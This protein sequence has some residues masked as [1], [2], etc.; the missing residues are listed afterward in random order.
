MSS[1][2]KLIRFFGG[3]SLVPLTVFAFNNSSTNNQARGDFNQST[4]AAIRTN[5][6]NYANHIVMWLEKYGRQIQQTRDMPDCEL[7][8]V[9]DSITEHWPLAAYAPKV[10]QQYYSDRN[11]INVGSGGDKTENIL[12]R[13]ENGILNQISPKLVVLM[14]G[15]NNTSRGDS[16]SDI[17]KGIEAIIHSIHRQ[18]PKSKILLHAI[19][20]RGKDSFDINRRNNQKV[21][22]QLA[23]RSK[24]YDFVEFININAKFVDQSG[25][26]DKAIMPDL[27]HPNA[28]GYQI[29]AEAI[30]SKIKF[31]LQEK[32]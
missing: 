31:Y 29:W 11:V 13:L 21:N 17:V 9:G 15:T 23:L 14:A 1:V 20:P 18:S 22:V 25:Q 10:W 32:G 7:L 6:P 2:S 4:T 27:L 16:P 28:K 12:W 24:D 30:E 5:N 3:I 26:L 8:F 19:F